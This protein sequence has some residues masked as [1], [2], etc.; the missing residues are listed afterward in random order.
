LLN[1]FVKEV[2]AAGLHRSGGLRLAHAI[3]RS[4]EL[5]PTSPLRMRRNSGPRFLILCYHRIG[6]GG[7]PFYSQLQ[8]SQFEQQMRYLRRSCRII[9]L[10]Q[11][12]SELNQ[13]IGSGPS[14]AVTFDDGYFG[15]Y[16]EAFPVLR[17][18]EVPATVYLA[19][20]CIESGEVAWYDRV[21]LTMQVM[22]KKYYEIKVPRYRRFELNSPESR[23]TAATDLIRY[24]RTLPNE[25]RIEECAALEKQVSLPPSQ[26]KNRM[27]NW[28]QVRE[29]QRAGISFE[30]HTMTHPVLSRLDSQSLHYELSESKRI[31]E[32]RTQTQVSHFAYPFGRTEECGESTGEVLS[33]LSFR[34]AVTT[35]WGVNTAEVH[36][37]RLRRVQI[38]ENTSLSMFAFRLSCLLMQNDIGEGYL[39]K[40]FAQG[41]AGATAEKAREVANA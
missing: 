5:E 26:L 23:L 41:R 17:K 10:D 24:L 30:A 15:T 13:G 27:M 36:P 14:V 33:K 37:Y 34:S 7:I 28:D 6:L 32:R 19:A 4:Y 20:E 1:S 2:I 11:L 9:P 18:Y 21:F 38:G 3:S 35:M 22:A 31:I 40:S 25:R 39:D 12:V 29:M 16:T 8:T